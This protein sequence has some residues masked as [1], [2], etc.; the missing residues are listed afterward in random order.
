MTKGIEFF[1]G[2][3]IW[4]SKPAMVNTCFIDSHPLVFRFIIANGAKI[5]T[6][7]WLFFYPSNWL[8]LID[9]LVS[10]VHDTIHL[11]SKSIQSHQLLIDHRRLLVPWSLL[12]SSENQVFLY[13]K[14]VG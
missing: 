14:H 11:V 10:S 13:P 12:N 2:L 1:K 5:K 3:D 4:L 7:N 9:Y 6:A 8:L